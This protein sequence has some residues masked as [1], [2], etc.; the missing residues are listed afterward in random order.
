[1]KTIGILM[2]VILAILLLFTGG[3]D[4][5]VEQTTPT[6]VQSNE[7]PYIDTPAHTYKRQV[8]ALSISNTLKTPVNTY[9]DSRVDAVGNSRKS[10]DVGNKRM[11]EQ[12]KAMEDFLK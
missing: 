4:T 7:K 2:F 10:V 8:E 3:E 12:N 6:P 9:L 1:M 5:E 11:E